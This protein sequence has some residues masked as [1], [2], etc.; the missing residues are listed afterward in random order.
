M[1]TISPTYRDNYFVDLTNS[2]ENIV[3]MNSVP[4]PTTTTE[5]WY[6]YNTQNETITGCDR[7][8]KRERGRDVKSG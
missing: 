1:R 7:E 6:K 8:R 3:A 4:T 5:A 2:G